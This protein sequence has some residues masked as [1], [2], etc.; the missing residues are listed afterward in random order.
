MAGARV[1][2]RP[3]IVRGASQD[4]LDVA[5][6]HRV[7]LLTRTSKFLNQPV[8][9]PGV[10]M[11]GDKQAHVSSRGLDFGLQPFEV[12]ARVWGIRQRIHRLLDRDRSELLQTAPRPYT[13]IRRTGWQLMHE[14]EPPSRRLHNLGGRCWLLLSL[15]V[16]CHRG[17]RQ[18]ALKTSDLTL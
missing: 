5:S 8:V 7:S 15:G 2:P 18:L 13:Q 4:L 1:P 10:E 14:Q 6:Q 16:C 12:F 17:L 9:R 11:V 3:S